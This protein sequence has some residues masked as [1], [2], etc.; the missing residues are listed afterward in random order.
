MTRASKKDVDNVEA[1]YIP[2][3]G[4]SRKD[5]ADFNSEANK[6]ADNIFDDAASNMYIKLFLCVVIDLIGSSS[7]LLPVLGEVGDIGW[8]PLEAYLLQRLFGSTAISAFGLIEEALPGLDFIPTASIAWCIE[9]F[10]SLSGLKRV[11]FPKEKH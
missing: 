4:S 8:A 5:K 7:Y 9:N 2:P 11:L 3:G 6:A 1:E 10:E